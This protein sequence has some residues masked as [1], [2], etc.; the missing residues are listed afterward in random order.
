M[1]LALLAA[2]GPGGDV[3]PPTGGVGP[4]LSVVG[5]VQGQALTGS[6][7]VAALGVGGPA[8]GV[9]F[10]LAGTVAAPD[11]RGIAIL[12]TRAV[13]DGPAALRVS[14]TVAGRQ[15]V[16]RLDVVIANGLPSAATLGPAGG[17]LRS[18]AGSVVLVP[19][20]AL[21]GPVPVSVRDSS[22]QEI[23]DEFGIDY[24]ALGVTFLG[25]VG[26]ENGAERFRA[27]VGLDMAGWAQAMQPGQEAVMFAVLPDASGNGVG[28]LTFAANAMP[29]PDGSVVSL[30]TVR[31]EVYGRSTGGGVTPLQSFTARPGEIVALQGRGFNPPGISSNVARFASG[32]DL[33]VVPFVLDDA[34]FG[35][36]MEVRWAV[37]ALGAGSHGVTLHNLTTGYATEPFE[38]GV[39]AL[40]SGS[41]AS[42]GALVGQVRLAVEALTVGRPDLAAAAVAGLA[43]LEASSSATAWGMAAASG[44]ASAAHRTALEAMAAGERTAAQRALVLDH[45]LLLD[46]VAHSVPSVGAAAADLA[47]LLVA[48]FPAV[49]VEGS[50]VA[51][52]QSG[53]ESCTRASNTS[54]DLILG[55]TPFGMGS[56]ALSGCGAGS[57]LGSDG[58]VDVGS[59]QLGDA[60][61]R[62]GTLGPVAAFVAVFRQGTSERLTPFTAVTDAAGYFYLPFVPPGEPFTVRAVDP[63]T[64]AIATADGVSAGLNVLT[65][66]QLVFGAPQGMGD[67]SAAFTVTPLA[68]PGSFRFDNAPFNDPQ[69]SMDYR[70]LW[71]VGTGRAPIVTDGASL[72]FTFLRGGAYTVTLSVLEPATLDAA[73]SQRSIDVVLPY[74]YAAGPPTR[75]SRSPFGGPSYAISGDGRYVA[76]PSSEADLVPGDTNGRSDIFLY[77]RTTGS[78]ERVSLDAD[79]GEVGGFD[80]QEPAIS[81][82]GRYVAYTQ[83]FSFFDVPADQVVVRD[84]VTNVLQ[85]FLP[86]GGLQGVTQPVLS[87]DGR[88]L[89][90]QSTQSSSRFSDAVLH[91][92]DL[93]TGALT[94]VSEG[95]VPARA[96][97]SPS[98]SADGRRVAF[99]ALDVDGSGVRSGDGIFVRDLDAGVTVRASESAAGIA[100]VQGHRSP[101]ISADGRLVAFDSTA[102]DLVAGDLNGASDVFLKDLVTGQ[103]EV[104]SSNAAGV[105]AGEDSYGAS[106]SGDGRW[107][108]FGSYAFDFFPL[109]GVSCVIQCDPAFSTRGFSFVKDRATGWVAL[110][111]I[112]SGDELPNE[113]DQTDPRISADGRYVVFRSRST[114]LVPES[115]EI[116]FVTYW[117]ENPLW[118][119]VD[120]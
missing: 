8:L 11:E 100:A 88:T 90:F 81:A 55:Q 60:D 41:A 19:P 28:E 10:E 77:D 92:A 40:A 72:E 9:S 21:G 119:P 76:F 5:V 52:L 87:A 36:L 111:T 66:V 49:P 120:E 99:A 18:G 44:L 6:L 23:L 2:C 79:G 25:A 110:V 85:T 63:A 58:P 75:I 112:G 15:V 42:F 32:P 103:V 82:D 113:G 12:N 24:P 78:I 57:T 96:A 27:P 116:E 59:L 64:G 56:A 108:A 3:P 4:G 34:P 98:V 43:T 91:A 97:G 80:F 71:D 37:P 29:T 16:E 89:V 65:P 115:T 13:S 95:F 93:D 83:R 102:T 107:V 104:L 84:R 114:N 45:A 17:A 14:A 7:A 35:P 46:A 109:D 86:Q 22:Q 73:S 31:S 68:A 39:G 74:P 118:R 50:G 69:P 70:Y 106:M 20:G 54:W 53:D 67:L 38:L 62:L 47:T 48:L 101:R 51:P 30:P 33:L 26:V 117:V 94:S 61:G 105:Q 1:V